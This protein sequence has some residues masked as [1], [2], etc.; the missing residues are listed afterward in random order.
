MRVGRPISDSLTKKSSGQAEPF[1]LR[2]GEANGNF[3]EADTR[4]TKASGCYQGRQPQNDRFLNSCQFG[5]GGFRRGRRRAAGGRPIQWLVESQWP[6]YQ[7]RWPFYQARWPLYQGRIKQQLPFYQP[8][9]AKW[10]DLWIWVA[11][12]RL[13][14]SLDLADFILSRASSLS[15]AKPSYV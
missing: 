3:I 8:E 9:A 7:A 12:C 4:F 1:L 13:A 15:A 11:D 5:G 14:R 6:F 10:L 2:A